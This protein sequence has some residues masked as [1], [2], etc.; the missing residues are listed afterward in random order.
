MSITKKNHYNPTFWTAF[1]N[2]DYYHN[3][4]YRKENSS[5]Y[6]NV[7]SLN[8]KGNKILQTTVENVFYEKKMGLAEIDENTVLDFEDFFTTYENLPKKSL[9]DVIQQNEIN[10]L[11][12]K[13][14]VS[15]F[16][17]DLMIRHY[18]NFNRLVERYISDGKKKLDFVIDLGKDYSSTDFHK[19][20]IIPLVSSEWIIYKSEKFKFPLGDNPV[21]INNKNILIA[22]S[23]KM[24][25]KINYNKIVKPE[26]KCI[27]KHK[28]NCFLYKEFIY[29]TIDSSNRE[30]IFNNKEFLEKLQKS[31][32]YRKKQKN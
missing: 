13:T 15:S 28:I 6:Q 16:I 8:L 22:I 1:W 2:Y 4:D 29:R 23:P 17:A 31:K 20:Q 11:E 30:I 21:L 5:R 7:Y 24:L 12:E 19:S 14:W 27:I 25:L 32:V 3:A 10:S 18:E 9:L 26:S